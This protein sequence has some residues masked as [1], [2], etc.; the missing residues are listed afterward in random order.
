MRRATFDSPEELIANRSSSLPTRLR[1]V[2]IHVSPERR[3]F[4]PFNSARTRS[5]M[6]APSGSRDLSLCAISSISGVRSP[7]TARPSRSST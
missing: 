4:G 6:C 7:R 3:P 5:T 2:F 1:I